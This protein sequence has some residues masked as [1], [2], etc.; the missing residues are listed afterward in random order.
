MGIACDYLRTGFFQEEESLLNN[1]LH[2]QAS[3]CGP[4]TAAHAGGCLW[5]VHK[6]QLKG[7]PLE[8]IYGLQD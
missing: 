5:G 8:N 4:M 7:N 6:I 3:N 2:L 1:S